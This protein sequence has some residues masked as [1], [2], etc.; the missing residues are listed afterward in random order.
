MKINKVSFSYGDREIFKD[1]NLEI[2][3]TGITA[4]CGPS[5]CG[6]TTLL[7]LIAGL[8]VPDNGEI[9][10]PDKKDIAFLFQEDRLLPN[11]NAAGQIMVVMD[12]K[13]MADEKQNAAYW[14]EMVGLGSEADTE[15]SELSGGMKRRVALARCLAF[16]TDKKLLILDE[17][18]AGVDQTCAENIMEKIRKMNLPVLFTAHNEQVVSLADGRINLA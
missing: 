5:G 11:L 7:R 9:C 17:P 18:F 1:L 14:L 10:G 12:G 3:D 15:I 8:L 4:I 6:K 2:P 13:N 16:G